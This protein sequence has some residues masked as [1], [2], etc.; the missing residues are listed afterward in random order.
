M[1]VARTS[2]PK[3]AEQVLIGGMMVGIALI[4]QRSDLD[5]FKTGL[6][7]LVVCTL[8]QIAVGN[9]PKQGSILG[10]LVRIALILL[11]VAAIFGAGV[12]LVPFLSR[13]GR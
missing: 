8:L 4:T 7:V 3:R 11:L 9:I 5:L 12:L 10:S 13:L 6:S 1:T 2:F